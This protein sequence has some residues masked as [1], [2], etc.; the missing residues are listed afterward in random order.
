MDVSE[1]GNKNKIFP[2]HNVSGLEGVYIAGLRP[3]WIFILRDHVF[4]HYQAIRGGKSFLERSCFAEFHS[5]SCNDGFIGFDEGKMEICQLPDPSSCHYDSNFLVRRHQ[6][7]NTVR[8]ISFHAPTGTFSLVSI[9]K[10]ETFSWDD[11]DVERALKVHNDVYSLTLHLGGSFL[12]TDSFEKNILENEVIL[13]MKTVK[14][15]D[16]SPR[17]S[18]IHDLIVV[19]TSNY[20]GEDVLCRGRVL[21]LEPY[22]STPSDSSGAGMRYKI[23]CDQKEKGLVTAAEAVL[24]VLCV[25]IGP[26]VIVYKWENEKLTG[27]AFFDA[28]LYISSISTVRNFVILA[29]A[30]KGVNFLFWDPE[31]RQLVPLGKDSE[32]QLISSTH[33]LV[34]SP[35]LNLVVCDMHGNIQLM[36]YSPERPESRGGEKLLPRADFNVGSPITRFFP[37]KKRSMQNVSSGPEFSWQSESDH[38]KYCLVSSTSDGCVGFLS[39][40]DQ[41]VYRRLHSLHAQLTFQLAHYGGMNPRS[42][43]AYKS[44]DPRKQGQARNIVDLK[45]LHQF[46]SLD[47]LQ[48]KSLAK[49]IG[50]TADN[51]VTNLLELDLQMRL[52]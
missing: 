13:C 43:R 38:S 42:F 40:L 31:T 18:G 48:Q 33:F 26:R 37:L 47:L 41:M 35:E 2:F 7:K 27:C 24:G 17:R 14:L 44:S 1:S 11:E 15:L 3:A 5:Q 46:L 49:N 19:G 39:C 52:Y 8:F 28:Q 21:L 50:T 6:L 36:T 25:S 10:T 22:D 23:V 30:V 4:E 9:K 20:E 32:R 34:N 16:F 45:L 12:Q 29:D 51:I